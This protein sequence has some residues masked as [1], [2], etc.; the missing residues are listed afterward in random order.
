MKN[1]NTDIY[2]ILFVFF[3]LAASLVLEYYEF[4]VFSAIC[5]ISYF[6]LK[7]FVFD[8]R[9]TDNKKNRMGNKLWHRC[10]GRSDINGNGG[11]WKT[12]Y[13]GIP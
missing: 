5:F 6:F 10:I 1:S 3:S 2:V 7:V 13:G 8:G 11:R 9:N 12:D 4:T